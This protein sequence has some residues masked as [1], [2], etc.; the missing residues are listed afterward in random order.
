MITINTDTTLSPGT[1][2]GGRA[3]KSATVTFSPGRY[4]IVGGGIGTQDTNSHI[5]GSG[6]FFYNTYDANNAY[7][8]INFNA[9]S[10][11]QL[12]APKTDGT[13][14]GILFTK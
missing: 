9:N 8:P 12:S 14:A 7:G 2:C 1:Y 6:V 5:L 13:Y 11:V 10:D 4:I 3:V